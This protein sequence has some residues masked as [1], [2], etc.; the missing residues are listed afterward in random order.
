M[1][2]SISNSQRIEDNFIRTSI[3]QRVREIEVLEKEIIDI[4][5][6]AFSSS[7][8]WQLDLNKNKKNIHKLTKKNTILARTHI[9]TWSSDVS[10]LLEGVKFE[11]FGIYVKHTILVHKQNFDGAHSTINKKIAFFNQMRA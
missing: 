4:E 2:V 3:I 5:D 8:L 1:F 9:G 7:N 6:Q 11:N 10:G